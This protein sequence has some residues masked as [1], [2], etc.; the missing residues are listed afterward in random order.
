MSTLRLPPLPT[1]SEIVKIYKLQAM[2][3]LSQNFLLD[4]N[5]LDKIAR[6]AQVEKSKFILVHLVK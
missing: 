4:G 3:K 2:K 6:H 1:I 5:I